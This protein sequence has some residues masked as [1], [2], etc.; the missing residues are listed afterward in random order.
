MTYSPDFVAN[1]GGMLAVGGAIFGHV[2]ESDET[3]G[4]RV[5][6][7]HERILAILDRSRSEGRPTAQ[8]AD[9]MAREVVLAA[10]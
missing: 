10:R 7:I 4:A 1:S 9:T 8:I 2:D 6:N 3:I 5:R